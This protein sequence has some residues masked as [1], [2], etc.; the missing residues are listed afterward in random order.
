MKPLALLVALFVIVVGV[1]GMLSPDT[2]VAAGRYV[3]TP[4]GIYGVAALRV[5]VGVV[6]LLVAGT[7]RA[8]RTLRA[9][10]AVVIAAG[11]ATPLIGAERSLMLMDW[12][13][14]YGTA[15]IRV[16]AAAGVA[17]GGL[18]AFAVAAGRRP[19]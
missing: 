5:A 13:L 19:A 8:P 18:L 3:I 16:G 12:E 1:V 2:L 4:R 9:L 11:L 7:S 15:P 10:G 14:S 6:L 17:L